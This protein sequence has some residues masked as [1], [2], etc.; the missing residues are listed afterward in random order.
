MPLKTLPKKKAPKPSNTAAHLSASIQPTKAAMTFSKKLL[1]KNLAFLV[2]IIFGISSCGTSKTDYSGT[3]AWYISPKQNNSQNLYGVAAGA[4][5]EEV[6]KSALAD[7][8]ARLMVSIS[9]ESS[10]IRQEDKSGIN[11]EMRQQIKQNIEKIDFSNFRVSNSK[12]A[13]PQLFVEVEIS[14]NT[15]IN[16]QKNKVS[17]AELQV[18]NLAKNLSTSNPIQKRVNLSKILDLE[19]QIELSSRIL[20]GSG[21]EMNLKEKLARMAEFKN[22]FNQLTDKIEF[23]F[24][25]NSPKEIA[26]VIRTA[27]NK[28][29]IKIANSR[30]NS[31]NQIVIEIRSSFKTNE[32]YGT[33]LTKLKINLEN[34]SR[35][36]T[37]ASNLLEVTGSSMISDKE[38]Y[39]A[40]VRALEDKI[41]KD[42]ILEVLGII[43]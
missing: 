19:K 2:L 1:N 42:G 35:G 21:E 17:F 26:Q 12:K 25:I 13:G 15:F 34:I 41:A 14:R 40:S 33:H 24:E 39:S 6:T 31:A 36:K 29:K 27:L 18:T 37:V 4:N 8:A 11:E 43:N 3:P 9:S 32:I 5:L 28:E 23:Y 16:D 20:Q 30:T 10:L 22:Q 7:A 38:S